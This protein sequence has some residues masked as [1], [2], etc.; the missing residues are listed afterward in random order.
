LLEKF[1]SN[2]RQTA[3]SM[4]ALYDV[5]TDVSEAHEV[6]AE[7]PDVVERLTALAEHA[8]TELGNVNRKGSGQRE[9]GYVANPKALVP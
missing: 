4:V 7:H 1:V 6:S 9:A 5:R 3:P 8:R 2:N